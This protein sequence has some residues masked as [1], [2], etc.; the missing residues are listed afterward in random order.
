MLQK[1]KWFENAKWQVSKPART[2]HSRFVPNEI[3]ALAYVILS[4]YDILPD[5]YWPDEFIDAIF[6]VVDS[7][8]LLR[9]APKSELVQQF[10]RS[11][12]TFITMSFSLNCCT[13]C[14]RL[15]M[16]RLISKKVQN[17]DVNARSR[18]TER[19]S[20]H[21]FLDHLKIVRLQRQ[22]VLDRL[23]RN[24]HSMCMKKAYDAFR[25]DLSRFFT[26]EVYYSV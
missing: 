17:Q 7:L 21:T 8:E 15:C 5:Q 9:D 16:L 18:S 25:E 24:L 22:L 19:E 2:A 3:E 13:N 1:R 23:W 4:L 26:S 10:L 12:P 11:Y 6:F 20:T 14:R